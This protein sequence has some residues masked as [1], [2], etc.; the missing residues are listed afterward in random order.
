M[1]VTAS[2]L[3][4][5]QLLQQGRVR[6]SQVYA[7]EILP[8]IEFGTVRQGKTGQEII[9]IAGLCLRQ[10]RNAVRADTLG[11]VPVRFVFRNA[12]AEAADVNPQ[13][14]ILCTDATRQ[15]STTN[16]PSPNALFSLQIALRKLAC[17]LPSPSSG[18]SS[19][20]RVSRLWL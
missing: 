12:T 9:R 20:A 11:A 7:L 1:H 15:R 17:A 18:Q 6:L 16:T 3:H 4:I 8:L 13:V 10:Q 5:G 19:A 14:G 2:A